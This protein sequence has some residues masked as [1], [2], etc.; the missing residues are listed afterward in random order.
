VIDRAAMLS[1]WIQVAMETRGAL[2]N[3]FAFENIMEALM[4]EQVS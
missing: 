1:A 3:L 4:S 2:G